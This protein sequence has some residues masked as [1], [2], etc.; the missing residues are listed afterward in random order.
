ML[1]LHPESSYEG[2]DPVSG[3]YKITEA[4]VCYVRGKGDGGEYAHTGLGLKG[5]PVGHD[6]RFGAHPALGDGW[7]FIKGGD[8]GKMLPS[9]NGES[10]TDTDKDGVYEPGTCFVANPDAGS[11]SS[12]SAKSKLHLFHVELLNCGYDPDKLR[13][14]DYA[15]HFVGVDA[16]FD[17]AEEKFKL[18]GSDKEQKYSYLIV[19]KIHGQDGG[20]SSSARKTKD[21]GSSK[22][23]K[24]DG[25]TDEQLEKAAEIAV[26]AVSDDALD[27]KALAAKL[28]AKD[29]GIIEKM[30][31]RQ[32]AKREFI[33]GEGPF[34]EFL[35]EHDSLEH[36]DGV[37]ASAE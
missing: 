6:V 29:A 9:I 20:G 17:E 11:V 3:R 7:Q 5:E 31:P 1:D 16:D 30:T 18:D 35:A 12:L 24:G 27:A 10:P 33:K 28:F 22:S 32:N 8:A 37:F 4:K 25:P 13:V 26:A 36:E 23:P 15:E 19:R 2:R 14:K 21:G 34:Y